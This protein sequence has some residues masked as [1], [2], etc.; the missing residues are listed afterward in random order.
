VKPAPFAYVRARSLD[1]VLAHLDA[2]G[3]AK[4]LA[5]GQSLVPLL[6][7]RLVRPA[8]LVDIN[9]VPGLDAVR[10]MPDGGL[11]I[12][13]LLRHT[14]LL[15]SSLVRERAP[16]LAAATAHIGHRAIRN[17]GTVGGSLAHGDPAAELPAAAVALEAAMVVI[18]PGGRRRIAAGEFFRG[19]LVT[20]L[21]PHEILVEIEIPG[22]A[23]PRWG[24]A[25]VARRAGDF[26]LAG[27]AAV[28]RAAPGPTGGSTPRLVAFGVG[29]TP[30]RL[31][32]AEAQLAAGRLD[33]DAAR[34]AGRAA[35]CTPGDDV[36]AS[37][38]Y[39]RHLVRVLTEQAIQ[40][41]AAR[42]AA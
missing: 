16:L 17:R 36:H 2:A 10:A 6:N 26:A 15:A 27:V 39:R 12:G 1:E 21:E 35:R 4:L 9:G 7:M 23:Q 40:D 11:T 19:P 29:D 31:P 41:A 8:T 34:A 33:A 24:F 22:P 42:V 13:A 5:G 30:V 3:E 38:D 18:G 28:L 14:D 37:A 20:A 25:E 32:E